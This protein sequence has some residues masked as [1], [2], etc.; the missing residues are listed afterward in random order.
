MNKYGRERIPFIFIIDYEQ[1]SPIVIPVDQIDNNEILYY[2]EG[3]T[4]APHIKL[5]Q[6]KIT[7]TKKPISYNRYLK[8]FNI[9]KEN[10]KRGNSFLT[11]LTYPTKIKIN[12]TLKEIFYRSISKYKLFYKNKFV[13]FSP[14]IFVR[15]E[16]RQIASYPMKGTIDAD[17]PNA[18]EKI[19]ADE[20][21]FAEHITIVDLI[22]NDI[23]MVAKDVSVQKFR[24]IDEIKTI[25]KRL[26]QVSSKIVGSLESDFASHIG[27]I[28]FKLLPAGSITGAPKK[29]TVQIIKDAEGYNR[30]YYTGVFGYFDGYRMDSGVMIRFIEN[31]DG[32]LYYKSGGGITI[33][34]DPLSEYNELLDKIYV[35]IH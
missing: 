5:E 25:N 32:E 18:R 24:Y 27:D 2:L 9:L 7:I 22:R 8:G 11:N 1:K 20:K 29:K 13:L 28:I 4:N 21:E 6:K 34:S 12:L 10:F 26:F 17:I 15:I 14:E 33:Y 30:G 31:K 23:G 35:P 19:L 16:D 3:I